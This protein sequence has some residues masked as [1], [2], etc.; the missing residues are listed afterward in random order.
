MND[1]LSIVI[2]AAIVIVVV[3]AFVFSFV[4]GKKRKDASW[5][6]TV[7]DKSMQEHVRTDNDR[8]DNGSGMSVNGIRFGG[9]RSDVAVTHSYSI[10]VRP[11]GA[12]EPF[13]WPISSGLYES[14]NI[15]DK[16][17]KRPG[18]DVPE[19]IAP[20]STPTA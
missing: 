13:D 10:T 5:T 18:T 4:Q 6:G 12:G 3:G 2:G 11:D 7:I 17:V 1:T 8:N 19:V 16:L 15:G 14:L 9:D 20:S